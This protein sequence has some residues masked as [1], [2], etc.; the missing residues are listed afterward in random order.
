MNPNL[1]LPD[2]RESDRLHKRNRRLGLFA[3]FALP[4]LLMYT[5]YFL[6][7]VFP[8]GRESVLVLDLNAQYVYFFGALRNALHG[9][10]SLLY[11]FSRAAGGEFLGI[12]AYYLSSPLSW[13][14]ALFPENMLLD[15]LLVLFSTKCG[16]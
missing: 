5:V 2:I 3:A 15:A 4:C 11:S 16:L 13:I 10:G 1:V 7:G 14:V 6:F 8:F 9:D 12:F